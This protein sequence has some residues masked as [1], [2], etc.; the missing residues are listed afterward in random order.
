MMLPISHYIL[1]EKLVW[2]S[3]VGAIIAVVGIALLFL[4]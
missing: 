2:Q 4:K 3:I 1:K